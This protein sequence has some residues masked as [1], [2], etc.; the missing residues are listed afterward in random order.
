MGY[1][2]NNEAYK[3]SVGSVRGENINHWIDLQEWRHLRESEEKKHGKE[4]EQRKN[5]NLI[6]TRYIIKGFPKEEIKIAVERE[7]P[8][9]SPNK[10]EQT[11]E[12]WEEQYKKA[13]KE[14]NKAIKKAEKSKGANQKQ[15]ISVESIYRH[16]KLLKPA[17]ERYYENRIQELEEE[18]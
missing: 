4:R 8:D 6:V 11:I 1:R 3:P 15:V 5:L 12:H 17:L 2:P 10:I 13:I 16:Y 14:I 9:E 7:L 18:K